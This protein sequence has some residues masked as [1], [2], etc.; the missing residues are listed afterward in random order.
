MGSISGFLSRLRTVPPGEMSQVVLDPNHVS[1][2]MPSTGSAFVAGE[3]YF[4]VR[5]K[6]L[7]LESGRDWFTTHLPLLSTACD[8][9]YGTKQT[10]VPAAVGPKMIAGSGAK[11]PARVDFE[12]VRLCGITPYRGGDL[13][14]SVM[15]SQINDDPG[16]SRLLGFVESASAVLKASG[17]VIPYAPVVELVAS[18]LDDLAKDSDAPPRFGANI[19]LSQDNG[20]FRAGQMVVAAAKLSADTLWVNDGEVRV[21]AEMASAAP[22]TC[23]HVLLSL[24]LAEDRS[25]AGS[26]PI[27]DKWWPRVD[28]LAG[29]QDEGSWD[30]AKTW[31]SALSQELYL[32]ADLT[33]P[34]AQR[35]YQNYVNLAV[36]RHNDAKALVK[37]GP[38]KLPPSEV[39]VLRN[40]DD[41]IRAL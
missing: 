33:R 9:I 17:V 35:L 26:L 40:I 8:Y 7:H 22:L 34:Q 24:E 39:Q 19:S 41:A 4:T 20:T 10:T 31:L 6:T 5:L 29:R 21:G 2:A 15:L 3:H 11:L 28:E 14:I 27:V 18:T 1:P 12:D 23:D 13:T 37:L 36:E 38:G 30:T 16:L 25:D 32:S